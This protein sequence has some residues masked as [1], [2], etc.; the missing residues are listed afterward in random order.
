MTTQRIT[1]EQLKANL[2]TDYDALLDKITDAINNAELGAIIDQSE[3]PVRDANAQFRERAYQ[4]AISLLDERAFSPSKDN[5][6]TE[7]G[8]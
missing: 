7:M 2:S 1:K 4:E 5:A 6:P 3:E 8:K